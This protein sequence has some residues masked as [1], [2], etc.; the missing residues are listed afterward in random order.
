[1]TIV[2]TGAASGM[3]RA[4]A[5]RLGDVLTVDLRDADVV[6]DITDPRSVASLAARVGSSFRGLVHAAGV[7]PTMG[8]VRTVFD[9]DLRGTALLLDGFAPFAGVGAA[10]VCFA[11][12][13]G[14]MVGPDAAI[15][16]VCDDPLAPDFLDRVTALVPD[17]QS[18]YMW[19]KRGVHRLVQR[20]SVPWGRAGAR[21]NSVSPGM[22]D[23][24][25]NAQEF[26]QQPMMKAMLDVT[27][28][29]RFGRPDEIAAVVEFLLSEGASFVT[30]TDLVVDGA[31]TAGLAHP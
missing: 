29:G 4:C 16:A 30:G 3:G 22:I 26:E 13:A 20:T 2:V 27:P 19:A 15:D 1:M 7:S 31:V 25:M 17:P 10:A 5:E 8:D 6:C 18:G 24:P 11:S 28:L 9:V 14:H 23:T 21:V 12:I